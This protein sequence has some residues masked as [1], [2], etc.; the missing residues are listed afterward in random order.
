MNK[1]L[2]IAVL[3]DISR[4]YD[5]DLLL[6]ITNFNKL[7]DRF[8]FFFY[9]PK[10]VHGEDNSNQIK[11]VI[12]W[13]PDG[14]ITREIDGLQSL[15]DL[16][17]PLILVPYKKIFDN[18]INIWGDNRGMGEL[19]AKYFIAKGFKNYAFFGF[20]DFQWSVERQ[21]G[22][23]SVIN[24]QGL[25]VENFIFDSANVLW[26]D[27]P[28]KL[29]IWLSKLTKPCAVFSAND[30]LNLHL[31]EA[32]KEI[33][34]KVPDDLSV[35]GVDNDVMICE[36]GSPTLSSIDQNGVWA[37]YEAAVAL[38]DWI[39]LG[40]KPEAN[41][42]ANCGSV[43]NRNSSD[44]FAIDD[45]QVRIAL[46]YIANAAPANDISVNDVVNATNLSRRILEMRF[47]STVKS[48][49]LEEI[50]KVRIGRIKFLLENSKLT[51]QQI[52]FELNF[53][54]VDNI[55]RYFKLFTGLAP[56]E[57]RNKNKKTKT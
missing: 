48:S 23:E 30:E 15:L 33:D 11:R 47:Q 55:T 4:T 19:A 43:I 24:D 9:A 42:L 2:K 38:W 1:K 10:Y 41:I 25:N 57:Y 50:K 39:E 56:L 20:K 8:N 6:G 45:D 14:I 49:I 5:R 32:A 12:A 44:A 40:T 3:L 27:I 26:E 22:F 34:I 36:M 17:I 53:K 52:S 18:C 21:E 28:P 16:N 35:I 7:R 31:L 51:V 13:Q 54:N 37:G 46:H 29:L